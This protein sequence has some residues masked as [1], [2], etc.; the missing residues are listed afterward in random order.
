MKNDGDGKRKGRGFFDFD[1]PF[2]QVYMWGV[3][4]KCKK[5]GGAL[6]RLFFVF[7]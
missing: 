6:F 5:L 1:R 3:A 7:S 4:C 2:F